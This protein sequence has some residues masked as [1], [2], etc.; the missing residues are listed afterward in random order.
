[1]P[2]RIG[3]ATQSALGISAESIS[4]MIDLIGGDSITFVFASLESDVVNS[5]TGMLEDTGD[6]FK[7]SSLVETYVAELADG[8]MTIA[9]ETFLN[10]PDDSDTRTRL[11][12]AASNM[13]DPILRGAT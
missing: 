7:A 9:F 13:S 4:A 1:M 5:D 2:T 11:Y 3:T 10:D 12:A 6:F 8:D